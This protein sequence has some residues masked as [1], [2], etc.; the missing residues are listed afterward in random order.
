[1]KL[2]SN[3]IYNIEDEFKSIMT[4]TFLM[5]DN[6]NRLANSWPPLW[7]TLNISYLFGV[8]TLCRLLSKK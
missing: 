2:E 7:S 3:N 8:H 5:N 4:L 6:E 1:M